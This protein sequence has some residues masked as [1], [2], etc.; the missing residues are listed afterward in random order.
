MTHSTRPGES[1]TPKISRDGGPAQVGIDQDHLA[2]LARG[3][4]RRQ[5]GGHGAHAFAIAATRNPQRADRVLA[6]AA[7]ASQAA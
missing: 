5:V 2:F 1:G 3:R 6:L 4:G 7:P